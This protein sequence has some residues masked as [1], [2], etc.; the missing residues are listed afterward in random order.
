MNPRRLSAGIFIIANTLTFSPVVLAD[1]FRI[2]GFASIVAG[3]ALDKDELGPEGEYRGYTDS[4]SL[5]SES[6]YGI[7]FSNSFDEGLSVVGQIVGSGRSDNDAQFVWAYVSY[8]FNPV[9]T[10]KAG[11]QRLPY[12]LYSDFLD[13]GYAYPWITPPDE[14]YDLSGFDNLDGINLEFF[15]EFGDTIS[16]VNI[17]VGAS[18]NETISQQA[19]TVKVEDFAGI[20]WNLNYDWLTFQATYSVEKVTIDQIN[21]FAD[22]IN[23]LLN[24]YAAFDPRLD[25]L[26]SD[27]LKHL[28][29]EDSKATFTGVGLKGDWDSFFTAVEY[30]ESDIEDSPINAEESAW[31][32]M[33]GY[34]WQY[35]TIALTYAEEEIPIPE[36]SFNIVYDQV[37]PDLL[38]FIE[39]T[40]AFGDVAATGAAQMLENLDTIYRTGYEQQSYTL[41]LRYDFHP[42]AALKVEYSQK[43]IDFE[44]GDGTVNSFEPSR[45]AIG[46]DLVF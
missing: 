42:S 12:F 7:Q 6:I 4:F 38:L 30:V 41:S 34:R 27:Q 33:A 35:F 1:K 21:E 19:S 16:R 8:A 24:N 2:D 15:N 14:V 36:E 26:T 5:E 13:V 39:P 40:S 10:I 45:L 22:G 32:V 43:E 29:V 44:Q 11:R 31:Y 9:F 37:Q 17:L 20:T 23:D 28:Q 3:K 18:E 25:A 46:V